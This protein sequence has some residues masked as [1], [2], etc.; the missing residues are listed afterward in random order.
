MKPIGGL[1]AL[2]AFSQA[3]R[4]LRPGAALYVAHAAGAQS[5]EFARA[6]L[7]RGWVLRQTL[8]WVKDA[9]VLGR[10]DYHY[11]HEPIL[12]GHKAGPGRWGRGAKGWHGRNAETSVLEFPRPRASREHPTAVWSLKTQAEAQLPT[13]LRS[14]LQKI[15]D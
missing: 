12:Y 9:M 8:V 3:D 15:S 7:E 2:Q 11:R 5:V 14:L 6:F 13:D 10:S 1:R 4:A